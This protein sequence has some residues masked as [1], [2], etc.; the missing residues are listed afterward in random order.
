M[1]AP[2]PAPVPEVRSPLGQETAAV[3][4]VRSRRGLFSNEGRQL[5]LLNAEFDY[6]VAEHLQEHV[7][8][9]DAVIVVTRNIVR[10]KKI[11]EVRAE[12]PFSHQRADH[13]SG[14]LHCAH[15][16]LADQHQLATGLENPIDFGQEAQWTGCVVK[17]R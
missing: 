13:P 8:I 15:K 4:A 3:T 7:V 6:L 12:S 5:S 9:A 11:I 16:I 2:N 10:R 14:D 1:P 17:R